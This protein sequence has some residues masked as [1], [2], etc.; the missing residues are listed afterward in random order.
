MNS[1]NTCQSRVARSPGLFFCAVDIYGILCPSL[2]R[3]ITINWLW[4]VSLEKMSLV[5]GREQAT[6]VR[7]GVLC[8]VFVFVDPPT[9]AYRQLFNI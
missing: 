2:A 5:A 1:I 6:L 3:V 4:K 7:S 8:F 9:W